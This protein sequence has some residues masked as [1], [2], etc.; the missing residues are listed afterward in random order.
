MT[1]N[2]KDDTDYNVNDKS[3]SDHHYDRWRPK[4]DCSGSWASVPKSAN[5]LY[6]YL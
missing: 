3:D 2:D 6:I 5:D 4:H 1:T